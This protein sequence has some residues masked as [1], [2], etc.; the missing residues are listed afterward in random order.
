MKN[1]E[2][3]EEGKS[4]FSL[5]QYLDGKHP[6]QPERTA[7]PA[8]A[9]LE[10]AEAEYDRIVS[11]RTKAKTNQGDRPRHDRQY[12]A[13]G[14]S[15]AAAVLIA[16]LLWPEGDSLEQTKVET[17]RE[18]VI[19]QAEVPK[20]EV[21]Q[22]ETARHETKDEVDAL[23]ASSMPAK[24]LVVTL[25]HQPRAPLPVEA[26]PTD[27]AAGEVEENKELNHMAELC[28]AEREM[29]ESVH[30]RQAAYEAEMMQRSLELLLYIMGQEDEEKPTGGVKT[31]KS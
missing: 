21:P 6:L 2:R 24:P 12:W 7:L 23:R 22:E 10:A 16:F 27:E 15:I 18:A 5:E 13:W 20:A 19:V 17:Q 30:R 26:K 3:G 25:N 8:E 29:E 28:A 1:G 9:E 14:L 4:R 31:Q 11:E